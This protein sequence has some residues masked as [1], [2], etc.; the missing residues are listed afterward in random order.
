MLYVILMAQTNDTCDA[1][2]RKVEI[3]SI[4]NVLASFSKKGYEGKI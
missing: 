2:R 1:V 4:S 3:E